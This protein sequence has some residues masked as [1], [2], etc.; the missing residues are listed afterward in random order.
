MLEIIDGDTAFLVDETAQKAWWIVGECR[1]SIPI[2]TSAKT[3]KTQ[4]NSLTSKIIS[5]DVR[6]GSRQ[7]TLQQQFR[8]NLAI[9]P[10]SVDVYNSVRGVW[11]SIPVEVNQTCTVD[12]ACRRRAELP[13]C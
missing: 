8:F 2:E 10:A 9:R 6:I 3:S 11:S 7:V 4:N 1:R 5:D 13:E 12:A